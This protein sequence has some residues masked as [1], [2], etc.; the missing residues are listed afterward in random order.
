[1]CGT[2]MAERSRKRRNQRGATL[3]EAV[4]VTPLFL[5]IV[6]GMFETAFMVHDNIKVTNAAGAGLRAA[7]VEGTTVSADYQTLQ[8]LRNGLATF[9]PA[10]VER[11]VI[12][13][14]DDPSAPIPAGCLSVPPPPDAPCNSYVPSDF[15]LPFV[16]G[17]G[18][19]TDHW[20]CGPSSRDQNWCP[21]TR[22]GGLSDPGGP[23]HVGVYIR[24]RQANLTGLFGADREVEVTRIARIEPTT[25]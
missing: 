7:T 24:V 11:I 17:T 23:D 2:D 20:G 15:F 25:N 8:S 21:T 16:D 9:D 19:Q 18:A 14:A 12:F 3:I 6:M 10:D 22:Q 13:R 5:I 1:M 4:I